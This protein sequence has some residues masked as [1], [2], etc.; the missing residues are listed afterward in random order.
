MKMKIKKMKKEKT[1]K[2]KW[3][4]KMKQKE[5]LQRWIV[6]TISSTDPFN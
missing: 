4:K 3:K 2:K 6:N 5:P 1:T